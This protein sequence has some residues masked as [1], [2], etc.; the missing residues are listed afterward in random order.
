MK[1]MRFNLNS[2]PE[3]SITRICVYIN[4]CVLAF[5][6]N[7]YECVRCFASM[8]IDV[9]V[10]IEV[11]IIVAVIGTSVPAEIKAINLNDGI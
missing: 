10:L 9:C 5:Y 2:V 8:S 7:I 6:A 3:Q 4:V 1:I 11:C